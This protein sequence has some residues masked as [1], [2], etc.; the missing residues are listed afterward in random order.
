MGLKPGYRLCSRRMRF[1][2]TLSIFEEMPVT[3]TSVSF[4]IWAWRRRVHDGHTRVQSIDR[5]SPLDNPP[6]ATFRSPGNHLEPRAYNIPATH[7]FMFHDN[8]SSLHQSRIVR[9][10][11]STHLGGRGAKEPWW[12]LPANLEPRSRRSVTIR[13]VCSSLP[14]GRDYAR[15]VGLRSSTGKSEK[16]GSIGWRKINRV[17][18]IEI[19][20][21]LYCNSRESQWPRFSW[22]LS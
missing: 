18:V 22:Y 15:D 21:V 19:A 20:H 17:R 2:T 13:P 3:P 7:G 9:C 6:A 14:H 8:G 10:P 1:L 16:E 12:T 5:V 4:L 11:P